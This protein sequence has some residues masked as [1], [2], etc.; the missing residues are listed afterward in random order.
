MGVRVAYARG[1]SHI[2]MVYVYG[3]AIWGAFCAKIGKAIWGFSS[4]MKEPKLH[5]VGVFWPV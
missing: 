4:E 5:K 2:D 3:P 1:G